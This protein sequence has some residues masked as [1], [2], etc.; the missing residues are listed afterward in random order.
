MNLSNINLHGNG[1]TVINGKTYENVSGRITITDDGVYVNGK[2]IEE[3]E[4]PFV[5]RIEIYGHVDSI[6]SD[7]ADVT[8]NGTVGSVVSKNGN[9]RVS[10][11]VTGNVE[12]MNGN[13]TIYGHIDGD[14][15]TQNGNI[16]RM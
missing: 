3:Y 2:P 14:V 12:S 11:G 9:V 16:N 7:N 10:N 4:E 1:K 5:L 6:A 13:I 15:T 8:V